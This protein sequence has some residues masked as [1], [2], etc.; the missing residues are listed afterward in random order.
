L[1]STVHEIFKGPAHSICSPF[2]FVVFFSSILI[3]IILSTWSEGDHFKIITAYLDII[4]FVIFLVLCIFRLVV[5]AWWGMTFLC[6]RRH[7]GGL[8][9]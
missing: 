3:V 8:V 5:D 2:V 4:I 6:G 9:Y 7:G 1:L